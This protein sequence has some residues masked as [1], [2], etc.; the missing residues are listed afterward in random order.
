MFGGIKTSYNVLK[1][2]TAVVLAGGRGSG[3]KELTE[4][5]AKPAVPIAGNY[6]IIDFVLS[7]C[8]NSGIRSIGVITQY[9]SDTLIRHIQM[10]WGRTTSDSSGGVIVIPAQ[11]RT[12][13]SWFRGTADA[14]Y[15]NMDLVNP[16]RT[17][18]LLI[19]SGDQVYK[20][21]YSGL[22][23]QHIE[24]KADLTIACTQQPVA[25]SPK[26]GAFQIKPDHRLTSVP[27]DP[28]QAASNET[29]HNRVYSMGIHLFNIDCLQQELQRAISSGAYE[30]NLE[31]DVIPGVIQ[32][33]KV[34]GHI[35]DKEDQVGKTPYWRPASNIDQYYAINMDLIATVPDL[36]LYDRNW[37]I[38]TFQWQRAGAKILHSH[39]TPSGCVTRSLLSGGVVVRSATID[40][41]V[42]S[43]DVQVGEYSTVKDSVILPGANIGKRCTINN[44]IIGEECHV[45]DGM[46]IGVNPTFEGSFFTRS[47]GGILLVTKS[48]LKRF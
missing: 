14:I 4:K 26:Y 35:F 40:H 12:G 19:L 48:M 37:P 47:E 8:V 42:L 43:V 21:D 31:T 2:T 1:K 6:R 22:I 24:Q 38:R 30:H 15:Q 41:S 3:L 44:A 18:R 46:K 17:D 16:E 33:H 11:Q 28:H 23:A 34:Y 29:P 25:G 5:T 32:R 10:G 7:N 9:M 20:M 27:N 45:P 13:D 36:D 39:D